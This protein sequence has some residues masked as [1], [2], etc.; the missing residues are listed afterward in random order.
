MWNLHSLSASYGQ[1]PS[2]IIGIP[3]EWA[4]YQ[5]DV[6]VHYWGAWVEGQ[7]SETD[8]KGQPVHTLESLLAG[9]DSARFAPLPI[10]TGN[11]RTVRVKPDGTWDEE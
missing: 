3:G 7:L 1:R 10:D 9:N 5:L 6:A 2:R 4:A 8:D 11:L